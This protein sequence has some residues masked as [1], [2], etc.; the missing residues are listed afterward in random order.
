MSDFLNYVKN[1]DIKLYYEFVSQ[2]E[3]GEE[4]KDNKKELVVLVGPPAVGKSTYIARKFDPNDVSVVSRDDIVD[5]VAKGMGL[6]YDDMFVLPP[7]DAVPN[8]S[9]G[10]M[11]KY[12]MVKKAPLWMNWTKVVFQKI[13]DANETINS[14]LQNK[15]QEAVDSGKN[16][17]VDMTNM[18][19]K[20]R[21]NAL[22]YAKDKDFFRRA[23]VFTFAESDL[24]EIFNRMRKRSAEIAAAGGSKTIG[25]DVIHRMIKSFE[26][27]SPS[28]G[29]DKV[30]TV[31][32]NS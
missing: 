28:E 32:F 18:T 5:E 4:N 1:R 14:Q 2:D 29:F 3:F 6:T 21:Q 31:S 11:E 24:P 12:G 30:E 26:Q 10:G 25:E 17:V 16:V 23:V 9:V 8:T 7:S 20:I 22:R 15:F 19:A 13:Y 27:V